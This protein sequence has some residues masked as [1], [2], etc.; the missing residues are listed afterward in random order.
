MGNNFILVDLNDDEYITFL[1][2]SKEFEIWLNKIC[3]Q[4]VSYFL[5]QRNGHN[6]V[7]VGDQWNVGG[8]FVNYEGIINNSKDV[9]EEII[10]EMIHDELFTLEEVNQ[11]SVTLKLTED[12][13]QS[14]SRTGTE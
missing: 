8:I 11:F 6:I 7:F 1:G 10:I 3:S 4:M 5:F 12:Q 9:T 14:S 13:L 2:Y